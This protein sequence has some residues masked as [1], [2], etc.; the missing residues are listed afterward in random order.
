MKRVLVILLL[1][2]GFFALQTFY[3]AGQFKSIRNSFNGEIIQVYNSIPGPEAIVD[4]G[5][6]RT[7]LDKSMAHALGLEVKRAGP[8]IWFG[9]LLGPSA[10]PIPYYGQGRSPV[11]LCFSE[12]VVFHLPELKVIL[13]G[14][15]L[16]LLGTDILGSCRPT[17]WGF[18]SVG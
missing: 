8:R 18:Q 5:G 15:P 17:A 10:K 16:A 6:A 1:A 9:S 4:T 7:M 3:R 14:E 12:Q 2:I 11:T 13:H